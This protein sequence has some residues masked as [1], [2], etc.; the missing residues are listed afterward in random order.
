MQAQVGPIR[1]RWSR[2]P[3]VVGVVLTG[4]LMIFVIFS[5]LPFWFLPRCACS[6]QVVVACTRR[7]TLRDRHNDEASSCRHSRS[8]D[9]NFRP[10]CTSNQGSRGWFSSGIVDRGS[11]GLP[12]RLIHQGTG[13]R[14]R[15]QRDGRAVRSWAWRAA[16][17]RAEDSCDQP[18]GIGRDRG[19][20]GCSA[21]GDTPKIE[22][23]EVEG[24]SQNSLRSTWT[25]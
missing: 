15:R 18:V 1:T 14:G 11:A 25:A 2:E 3:K 24:K 10:S 23:A 17:H 21:V 12:G 22:R 8:S 20:G 6:K 16:G 9:Q 7:S 19:Q 4:G 13:G 5:L